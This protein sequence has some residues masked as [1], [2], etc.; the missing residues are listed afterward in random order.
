MIKNYKLAENLFNQYII[1]M[2][3]KINKNETF[4]LENVLSN[5]AYTPMLDLNNK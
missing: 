5:L 4:N 2:S 1:K 3:L